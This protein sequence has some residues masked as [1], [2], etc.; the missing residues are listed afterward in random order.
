ML[1]VCF[2]LYGR[3]QT[4]NTKQIVWDF[5]QR[6]CIELAYKKLGQKT[7]KFDELMEMIKRFGHVYD[8]RSAKNYIDCMVQN[9]WLIG[10]NIG[11]YDL[12][13]KNVVNTVFKFKRTIFTINPDAKLDMVNEEEIL[14]QILKK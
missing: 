1:T 13:G 5:F 4:M 9:G 8:T 11:M 12:L 7:L 3:D 6:Y 2:N 10:D 14:A